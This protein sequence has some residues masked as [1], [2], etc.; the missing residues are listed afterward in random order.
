MKNGFSA[1]EERAQSQCSQPGGSRGSHFSLGSAFSRFSDAATGTGNYC[2]SH[3]GVLW[4]GV[5]RLMSSAQERWSMKGRSAQFHTF[6]S[7]PTVS[8]SEQR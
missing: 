2:A 8:S 7:W 6:L 4:T 5:S 3:Q 1:A